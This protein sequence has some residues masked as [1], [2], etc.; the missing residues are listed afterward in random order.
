MIYYRLTESY[1]R[2]LNKSKKNSNTKYIIDLSSIEISKRSLKLF[3]SL[4]AFKHNLKFMFFFYHVLENI[5]CTISI[6]K[7]LKGSFPFQKH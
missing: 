3:L 6:N 2:N 5:Y 7:I 4:I 1:S